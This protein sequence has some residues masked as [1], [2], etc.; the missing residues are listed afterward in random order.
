MVWGVHCVSTNGRGKDRKLN[1]P[2]GDF[3]LG[4]LVNVGVRTSLVFFLRSYLSYTTGNLEASGDS[5]LPVTAVTF[6]RAGDT[7]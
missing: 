2:A 6:A 3:F 7:H 5:I 1:K 4:I